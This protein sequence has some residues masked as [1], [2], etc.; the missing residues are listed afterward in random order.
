M[1]KCAV[2]FC[3]ASEKIDPEFNRYARQA[4]RAICQKG[5]DICSGGTVK[6]TMRVVSDEAAAC[7]V[8]VRG[9]LPRFMKGLEHPALT[10]TVWTDSMS[11]RKEAMREGTDAAIA[12]PGGIGTLD[13]L[14]ETYTLK[15]MGLYEGKVIAFNCGGF[16][17]PFKKL[18]DH[19][20]QTAMLDEYSRTLIDFPESVEELSSLL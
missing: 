11:T 16:F 1:G 10:E 3:S 12:L 4:V 14:V 7:G 15:K 17:E 8:Q 20:V 18:L 13:E 19:M 2:I 6:G 9:V 5:Y